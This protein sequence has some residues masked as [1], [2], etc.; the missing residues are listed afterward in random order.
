MH[1]Q[2]RIYESLVTETQRKRETRRER[3]PKT[4]LKPQTTKKTIKLEKRRD[5]RR[6]TDK[7]LPADAPKRGVRGRA[8]LGFQNVG[9]EGEAAASF[10]DTTHDPRTT[11]LPR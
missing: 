3:S 6:R 7:G 1:W 9:G 2:N 4:M 5:R 8:P 11:G 10:G